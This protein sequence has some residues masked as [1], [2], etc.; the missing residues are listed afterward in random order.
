MEYYSAIKRNKTESSVDMWMD[1]KSAIQNE[2]REKQILCVCVCVCVCV[3]HI[4]TQLWNLEK[5]GMRLLS[6]LS[7]VQLCA[8]P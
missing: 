2:E 4:L 8:T 5:N 6:R 3:Y 1:L 7:R